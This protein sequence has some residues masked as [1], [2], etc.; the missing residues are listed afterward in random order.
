MA[1]TG[2]LT[3]AA[4]VDD[5][6][7]RLYTKLADGTVVV[8]HNPTTQ[9]QI[10]VAQ[11]SEDKRELPM[12]KGYAQ[13]FGAAHLTTHQRSC[14]RSGHGIVW[15]G[16]VAVFHEN[17]GQLYYW[18]DN[19][20]IGQS[21][22]EWDQNLID[23]PAPRDSK[24]QCMRG[25]QIAVTGDRAAEEVTLFYQDRYDYLCCRVAKPM[26]WD[27]P[28]A[29]GKAVKGTGIAA[30]SWDDNKEIRIY[31]QDERYTILEQSGYRKWSSTGKAIG[32]AKG[33]TSISAVHWI[34]DGTGQTELRVYSQLGQSSIQ[35]RCW[36]ADKDWWG[37]GILYDAFVAD[38]NVLAFRRGDPSNPVLSVWIASKDGRV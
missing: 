26:I 6:G 34:G 24:R 3:I 38:F 7:V 18:L 4:A 11:R 32:A 17:N 37:D 10:Q 2:P 19:R 29:L 30:V 15:D 5:S 12:Y 16:N 28:V 22:E 33:L 35:E 36:S 13:K 27:E 23:I 8:E 9:R 21:T 1:S 14:K 31:Y 25:T 20:P